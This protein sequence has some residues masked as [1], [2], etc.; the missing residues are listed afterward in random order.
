MIKITEGKFGDF[1]KGKVEIIKNMNRIGGKFFY[2][3]YLKKEYDSFLWL[4]RITF[5]RS[6]KEWEIAFEVRPADFLDQQQI[7]FVF[8]VFNFIKKNK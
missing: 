3:I 4:G 1:K 5:N 2:V 8:D 7:K 6:K